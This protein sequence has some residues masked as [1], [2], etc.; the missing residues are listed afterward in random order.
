MEGLVHSIVT[1]GSKTPAVLAEQQEARKVVTGLTSETVAQLLERLADHQITSMPLMA[2]DFT[3]VGLVDWM[4]VVAFLLDSMDLS[5][6]D[7][8]RTTP[9]GFLSRIAGCTVEPAEQAKVSNRSSTNPLVL[10][11]ASATVRDAFEHF[12]HGVHRIALQNADC[13]IDHILTQSEGA[14]WL[15]ADPARLG[16]AAPRSLADLG[17]VKGADS[18]LSVPD[19][20]SAYEAFLKMRKHFVVAVVVVDQAGRMVSVFSASDLK[21]V[22]KLGFEAL[23]E[24]VAAFVEK[25]HHA[26]GLVTR[27]YRVVGA[28][29]MTLADAVAHLVQENVHRMV[30]VDAD[31]HPLG[32]VTLSDIAKAVLSN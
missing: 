26:R 3:V 14:Q 20:V 7:A 30:V 28:P 4:D 18:V 12:S 29:A 1:D 9:D 6:E 25:S 5:A 23:L 27:R 24:P 32:V 17:L 13:V 31:V 19:S 8:R 2:P 21:A 22:Q 11:P 15:A 16:A 10:L